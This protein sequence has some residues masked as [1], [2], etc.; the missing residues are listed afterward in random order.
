MEFV[1]SLWI[2]EKT[3]NFA[4][5]NIKKAGFYNQGGECLLR[6]TE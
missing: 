4:L 6:G 3:P 2:S 1:S 5:Q